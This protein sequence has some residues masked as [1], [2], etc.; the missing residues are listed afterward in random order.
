MHKNLNSIQLSKGDGMYMKRIDI[1][2]LASVLCFF[3]SVASQE[4]IG[5]E[6]ALQKKTFTNSIGMK[7]VT[8][9]AGTFMM[10]SPSSES[11]RDSDEKQHQVTLTKGFYMQTTEVTQG[12]WYEVM[13]TR[14]WSGKKYVRDSTNNPAVYISWNDCQNFIRRLNQKEGSN[15]Y[16]LPTEAEWEYAC[17]AGSTTRFC[18][19][20]SDSILGNYA[21][22]RKNAWD[23]GEKYAHTVAKKQPNAW[24]LYDMYGNVWEWCQDWKGNYPSVSVTDPKGPSS[25]K[26][27]VLRGGSWSYLAGSVRSGDRFRYRP[28]SEGRFLGFRAVQ[29]Y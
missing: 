16:R 27:R 7:F 14:P 25:G 23:A 8:I 15:K 3:V 18:F 24:G 10:G 1:V 19:G 4:A 5:E 26:Y 12:Q 2:I 9:P 20:D 21:W 22:Y 28:D 11:G 29:N 17:R 6:K 13:G